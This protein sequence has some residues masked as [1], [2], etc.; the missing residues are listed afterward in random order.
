[1]YISDEYAYRIP[2]PKHMPKYTKIQQSFTELH[3]SPIKSLAYT[4]HQSML[5]H[6]QY[7]LTGYLHPQELD[8][9][10][11][12]PFKRIWIKRDPP[13]FDSR[14]SFVSFSNKQSQ[15]IQAPHLLFLGILKVVCPW[16]PLGSD[17]TVLNSTQAFALFK[18]LLPVR[19]EDELPAA[20]WLQRR[21]QNEV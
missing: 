7:R 18:S 13:V 21:I 11:P 2:N 20:D 10:P 12:I 4:N 15:S 5:T 19:L 17:K 8:I 14:I 9:R 3:C 1:M 16:C 6:T